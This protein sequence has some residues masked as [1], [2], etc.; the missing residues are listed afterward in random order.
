MIPLW[1]YAIV[2]I[3]LGIV[4]TTALARIEDPFWHLVWWFTVVAYGVII[5][6]AV[7]GY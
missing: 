5:G 2:F 7:I 4:Y 3:L 6:L 1:I